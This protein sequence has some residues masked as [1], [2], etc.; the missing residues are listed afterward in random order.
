MA[1]LYYVVYDAAETPP[2][3]AQVA[4]GLSWLP[5]VDA[6]NATANT[7]SGVQ[8]FQEVTGLSP[9]TYKASFVWHDAVEGYSNVVHSA[10]VA[11]GGDGLFTALSIS[12]TPV[13]SL[14]VLAGEQT[15]LF[16]ALS[17]S[18]QPDISLSSLVGH[19][20]GLFDNL[21]IS[22]Q[23]I[24][25]IDALTGQQT[26]QFDTLQISARPS[27]NLQDLLTQGSG[28]FVPIQIS[29]QPSINLDNLTGEQAG[30]FDSLSISAQPGV[31]LSPL[32][33]S[34]GGVFGTLQISAQPVIA[35]SDPVGERAGTFA[36][37]G[38]SAQPIISIEPLAGEQSG[39]F[40]TLQLTAQPAL[41]LEPMIIQVPV[42][43]T[44]SAETIQAIAAAVWQHQV[45]AVATG[46]HLQ[47]AATEATKARQMQTN[48]AV[49][50]A[51]GL[52]VTV[53]D[54]DLTTVLHVFDVTADKLERVPQ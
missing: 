23:P 18:V 20:A 6:G 54:D 1:T 53:Y 40:D 5:A 15:G 49:I 14:G 48:K 33:G 10:T 36:P 27:I 3:A 43:G 8:S 37:L 13:L 38:I 30:L 7:S 34:E 24:I 52:T 11:V 21:Q 29:A 42:T 2:T 46:T 28:L 41:S 31:V 22:S 47:T 12:T 16:G 17:A 35:L 39:L 4:S 19:Q 25:S 32:V 51:D 9:G 45:G 50:S 44:L 26:G